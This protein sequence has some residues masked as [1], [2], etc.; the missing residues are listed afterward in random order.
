MNILM[1]GGTGFVGRNLIKSLIAKDHH[2]YILT[3]TPDK[4]TNNEKTTFIS[5]H[6]PVEEL[7]VIHAVINLAGESLFGYWSKS[8]KKAILDSRIE[9]TEKIL[10]IMKKLDKKP[11]VF[12]SCSAVGLYGISEDLIFTEATA[13][14]GGDFLARVTLEWEKTAK[15][16]ETMGIRTILTRFGVI[17]GKEGSLPLM[18]LP[19]KMFAGGKIGNGEQWISWIHIED[20]VNLIQFCL[21]N[22]QMEGP[23]NVTSPNPKRN[24]DFTKTLAKVLKRPYWITAP[25]PL[26]RLAIGEMSQLIRK[27]QYVLPKK[28]EDNNFQFAYPNLEEALREIVSKKT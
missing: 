2:I 15:Q 10:D 25:S 24:K 22:K 4:Y 1:T 13:N 11:D 8:K 19:V 7:P 6:Y 20:V 3:R 21:F 28:A 18:S 27:G 9:T 12:I 26:I 5:Y 17:L 23:V 14:P 16:A